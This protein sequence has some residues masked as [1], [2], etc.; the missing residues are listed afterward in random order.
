MKEGYVAAYFGYVLVFYSNRSYME[1]ARVKVLGL[2]KKLFSLQKEILELAYKHQITDYNDS[3]IQRKHMQTLVIEFVLE[4]WIERYK[5]E[6]QIF[7][8]GDDLNRAD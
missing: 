1:Y 6:S 3:L 4:C 8:Q 2:R 7:W 5:E